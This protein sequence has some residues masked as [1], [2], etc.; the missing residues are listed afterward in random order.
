MSHDASLSS[1]ATFTVTGEDHTLG[2]SLS[3]ILNGRPDVEFVGYTIPHP[4]QPEMNI[5]IQ[6]VDRPAVD[7][8]R[9]GLEDLIQV[10]EHMK[11]VFLSA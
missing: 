6:V 3:C 4:T 2:N 11:Q 9:E 1:H 7:V 5:R 8:L 10:C